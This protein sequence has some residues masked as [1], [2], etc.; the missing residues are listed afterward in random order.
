ME[1]QYK[2]I[3]LDIWKEVKLQNRQQIIAS[4]RPDRFDGETQASIRRKANNQM[5]RIR[6]IQNKLKP[7]VFQRFPDFYQINKNMSS[8]I[9]IEK[10]VQALNL[11]EQILH[12]ID[13]DLLQVDIDI[14]RLRLLNAYML[15]KTYQ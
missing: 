8:D 4:K 13:F 10:R 11:N 12:K 5:A 7:F 9:E 14:I 6:A 1:D 15:L 3:V 2:K